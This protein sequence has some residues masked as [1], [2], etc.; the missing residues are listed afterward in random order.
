MVLQLLGFRIRGFHFCL[1]CPTPNSTLTLFS[2]IC[3]PISISLNLIAKVAQ[4]DSMGLF[5]MEQNQ[6]DDLDLSY[7]PVAWCCG[8]ASTLRMIPGT[9]PNPGM[10]A[11]FSAAY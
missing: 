5:Q 8:T 6:L 9:W 10:Q 11:W 3:S 2:L 4:S 1:Q 7:G